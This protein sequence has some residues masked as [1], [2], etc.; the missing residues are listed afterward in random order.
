MKSVLRALQLVNV[1]NIKGRVGGV[2][3]GSTK[4]MKRGVNTSSVKGVLG[5]ST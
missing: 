1:S 2:N 4:G 3:K 5:V